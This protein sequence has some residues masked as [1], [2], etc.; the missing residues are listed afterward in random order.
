MKDLREKIVS[1]DK[2]D[3]KEYKELIATIDTEWNEKVVKLKTDQK[4]LDKEVFA[5]GEAMKAFQAMATGPSQLLLN[6]VIQLHN[7]ST[8]KYV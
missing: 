5:K 6:Q 2:N 1:I 7:R 8:F 4:I 3:R